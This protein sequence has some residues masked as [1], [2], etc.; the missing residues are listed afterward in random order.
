M[1]WETT[2]T[3]VLSLSTQ[4]LIVFKIRFY[5]K[6]YDNEPL[7]QSILRHQGDLYPGGGGFF[8]YQ[9]DGSTKGGGLISGGGLINGILRQTRRAILE[10]LQH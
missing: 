9:T 1:L 4:N 5:I 3:L 2:L 10:S 7:F 8:W 6:H